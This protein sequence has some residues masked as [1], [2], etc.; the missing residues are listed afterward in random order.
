MRRF[1]LI[2]AS[3]ALML[4]AA[5][6]RVEAASAWSRVVIDLSEQHVEVFSVEGARLHRWPASTGAASTPTPTGRFK[7]TS[8]SRHTFVRDNPSVTMEHM[9]RFRGGIGFHGIPRRNGVP[10]P[11]PLGKRPVS[12]GCIRLSDANAATL[13]RNLPIGAVVIVRR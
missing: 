2:L 3:L 5:P 6:Q 7:V 1:L 11:T 12:H 13:F 8:K 10:L 9:T 4:S